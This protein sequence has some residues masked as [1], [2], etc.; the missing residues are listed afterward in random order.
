MPEHLHNELILTI[1]VTNLH[2]LRNVGSH[3]EGLGAVLRHGSVTRAEVLEVLEHLRVQRR[4]HDVTLG[5]VR[6]VALGELLAKAVQV[7]RRHRLARSALDSFAT[8]HDLK[9]VQNTGLP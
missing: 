9:V 2:L 7:E 1:V 6:T 3:Q 5:N 8:F 4:A